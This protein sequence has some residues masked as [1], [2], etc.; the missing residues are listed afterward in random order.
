VLYILSEHAITIGFT[1]AVP[2]DEL[3]MA[4]EGAFADK[5]VVVHVFRSTDL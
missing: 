1:I 4:I 2:L 3:V 5:V